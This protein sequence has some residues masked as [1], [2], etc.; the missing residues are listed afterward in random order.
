MPV[1]MLKRFLRPRNSQFQWVE[2]QYYKTDG[3]SSLG[4]EGLEVPL[5]GLG[6]PAVHVQEI[7]EGVVSSREQPIV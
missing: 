3:L 1:E 5:G 7:R 4:W 2:C 6:A